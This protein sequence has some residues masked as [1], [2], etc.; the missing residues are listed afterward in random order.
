MSSP[1]DP[2]TPDYI[3]KT[4]KT[5]TESSVQSSLYMG[6]KWRYPAGSGKIAWYLV[7]LTKPG[8]KRHQEA[9][10]AFNQRPPQDIIDMY[11]AVKKTRSSSS[12]TAEWVELCDAILSELSKINKQCIR[13]DANER[14]EEWTPP[15]LRPQKEKVRLRNLTTGALVEFEESA[16]DAALQK[17]WGLAD[18]AQP[19]VRV[20]ES[21][22]ATSSSPASAPTPPNLAT[23]TPAERFAALDAM[24]ESEQDAARCAQVDMLHALGMTSAETMA[25][26]GR[27]GWLPDWSVESVS[28]VKKKELEDE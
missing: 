2:P 26:M 27:T 20:A 4:Q 5:R 3:A 7:W 15:E 12:A 17:G 11:A 18:A 6:L 8:H 16:A 23:M 14:G 9:V 28:G 19:V 21:A 13:R 25:L 24:S 10:W 22:W 1:F